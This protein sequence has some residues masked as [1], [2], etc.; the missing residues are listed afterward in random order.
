MLLVNDRTLSTQRHAGDPLVLPAR[1]AAR[2]QLSGM[3]QRA[4][5]R[6]VPQKKGPHRPEGATSSVAALSLPADTAR[7]LPCLMRSGDF[8]LGDAPTAHLRAIGPPGPVGKI[9]REFPT[10]AQSD[11]LVLERGDLLVKCS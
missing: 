8:L 3:R 7:P 5:G 9:P 1:Y 6:T 4:H 10:G 2:A 11:Q